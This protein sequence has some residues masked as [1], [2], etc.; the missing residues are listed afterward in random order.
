MVSRLY[1]ALPPLPEQQIF[2]SKILGRSTA[3]KDCLRYVSNYNI[4]HHFIPEKVKP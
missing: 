3:S 2:Y 4:S 1:Y